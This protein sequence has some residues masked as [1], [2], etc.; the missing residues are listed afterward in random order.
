MRTG[1]ALSQ[2]WRWRQG[3]QPQQQPTGQHSLLGCLQ[4]PAAGWV[5]AVGLLATQE[6]VA[7]A[8]A[9]CVKGCALAAAAAS[10]AAQ[11]ALT[12]IALFRRQC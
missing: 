1:P 5:A 9:A 7:A 2:L 11:G 6:F 12:R 3:Q 4:Q 8:A 10:G